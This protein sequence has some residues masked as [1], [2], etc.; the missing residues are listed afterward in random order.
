MKTL[1]EKLKALHLYFV[2]R[3]LWF[4]FIATGMLQMIIGRWLGVHNGLDHMIFNH[5]WQYAGEGL[6][7][8]LYHAGIYNWFKNGV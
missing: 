8:S 3:R 5:W 1:I 2:M 6:F 7:Y 4:V